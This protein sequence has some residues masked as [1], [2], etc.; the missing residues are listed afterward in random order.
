M[1]NCTPTQLEAPSAAR[2]IVERLS[3]RSDARLS[4]GEDDRFVLSRPGDALFFSD[5]PADLEDTLKA[6]AD[7]MGVGALRP[8]SN[9][10]A[11]T[12]PRR[13]LLAS[14]QVNAWI[15]S[16][17]YEDTT[18]LAALE[19][20]GTTLR[21]RG[22][23]GRAKKLRRLSRFCVMR[24]I[25]GQAVLESPRTS[26]RLVVHDPSLGALLIALAQGN[27]SVPAEASGH[28]ATAVLELLERGG[29]LA[30]EDEDTSQR[31]VQWDAH[32]MLFHQHSR[33][34]R[35]LRPYGGTYHLRS[36]FDLP[37]RRVRRGADRI[38]LDRPALDAAAGTDP[39]LQA[40]IEQRRSIRQ[41]DDARPISRRQLGE[42][43][44]RTTSDRPA[45]Y[46][47]GARRPYP[48]GGAM[49]EL[50]VYPVVRLCDGL[51]PGLYWYDS[52]EHA[53]ALVSA[54]QSL[55][56]R[57]LQSARRSTDQPTEPQVLLVIAARVG[58]MMW[59]YERM[60]YA[61][62]LKHVGVLLHQFYLVATA[63][64]LAPCGIGGGDSEAFAVAS[65]VD[66][67]EEPNVG[68]FMLGSRPA[69]IADLTVA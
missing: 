59:K 38:D 69:E 28:R 56:A 22:E 52:A 12:E 16:T 37:P 34:G 46:L 62:V 5:L 67:Y 30:D 15:T 14:L 53:L 7:G 8:G 58:R 64:G 24:A 13:S 6:L 43:L 26:T 54:D 3:L 19:P 45:D 57:L 4:L 48:G 2:T 41:H 63:L 17:L 47:P 23:P 33:V 55:N 51:D 44:Y 68:E 18:P 1:T 25:D 50:Q 10:D 35:S 42:F 29:L 36:R 61:A 39:P 31:L 27:G 20:V 32:D 65:G 66:P 60:P 40:V 11:G 49:Y 9:G 21:L